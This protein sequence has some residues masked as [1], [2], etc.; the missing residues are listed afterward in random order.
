MLT[1]VELRSEHLEDAARLA[2]A[3]YATLRRQAPELPERYFDHYITLFAHDRS[4]IGAWQWLGFGNVVMDA[5][6][7]LAATIRRAG[8]DDLPAA[9]VL[10]TGLW[11]HLTAAPTFLVDALNRQPDEIERWLSEPANALWV[12]WQDGK[13]V[14]CLGLGPANHDACTVIR[15]EGRRVSSTPSPALR[16][17]AA[18]SPQRCSIVLWPGRAARATHAAPLT[19]R[20]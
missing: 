17:V 7:D 8:R 4:G 3:R 5:L 1:I 19:S 13:A 15:D 20:P 10:W 16:R 18:A 11:R 6:R 14:A 9:I 2:A 12:A